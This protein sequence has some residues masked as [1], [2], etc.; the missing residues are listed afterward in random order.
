MLTTRTISKKDYTQ[1]NQIQVSC[2]REENSPK[3]G[4]SAT[5]VQTSHRSGN[6][7]RHVA[8]VDWTAADRFR[9]T[10]SHLQLILT[11]ILHP[12]GH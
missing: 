12:A 4:S 1:K 2:D 11:I 6:F 9:S 3:F 8:L 7:A 10:E 5:A